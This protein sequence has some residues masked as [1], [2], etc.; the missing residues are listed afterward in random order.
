MSRS[1]A[2]EGADSAA[3]QSA[4]YEGFVRHRR[5]QPH[6]HEFSYRMFLLSLDLD[7]LDRVFIGSPFFSVNRRNLA[8]F[9]RSDFHGDPA[10]A[11]KTAVL[12][13]VEAKTGLRP[14]GAVRLL[15]H[16]RYF[17][18]CFNPVAFYYCYSAQGT[19]EV[20]VAEITNTPWRERHAYVLPRIKA[21]E[22]AHALSFD[23]P[24]AFHVSPFMPM[25]L[26]YR[27]RFTEP[28]LSL[29][30]HMELFKEQQLQFDVTLKMQRIPLSVAALHF[31]LLRYPLMTLRVVYFIHYQALKLWLKRTPLFN[32]PAKRPS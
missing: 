29:L 6:P 12:N 22:S 3:L 10:I 17:G 8:Q 32:H 19:L 15:A 2:S 13:T 28:A 25:A 9:R 31:A 7:E 30:V 20:I 26:D 14:D 18:H 21:R 16:L 27:W 5:A 4:I 11:L 23:F 1:G 24:K